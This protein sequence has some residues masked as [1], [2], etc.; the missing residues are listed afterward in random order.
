[1]ARKTK[2]HF[3]CRG[4]VWRSRL[5]E[6]YAKSLQHDNWDVTSSGIDADLFPN[7]QLGPWAK[8]AERQHSLTSWFS[9]RSI[10]TTSEL[11]QAQ[12]I[13]VFMRGD[14]YA[15]AQQRYEFNPAK[16]LTW[17][18]KDRGDWAKNLSISQK[19]QRTFKHVK[20]NVER[21][22]SDVNYGGW[23][24]IVSEDNRLQGFKMPISL[25]N[26][27]G[28]WHRCCHAVI[29]TPDRKTLVQKRS[30]NIIFAPNL[31]DVS[32]GG[33]VDAR[34]APERAM[35][36]EIKEELGLDIAED[37]LRFLEVN[38]L[39]SY[40]PRYK[41]YSKNFTYSYHVALAESKPAITVQASEVSAAIFVSN[42]RLQRLIRLHKLKGLGRLNYAYN[43]YRRTVDLANA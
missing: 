34:E 13:I 10:Q 12:D 8:I 4:N 9:D 25:T 32:I 16:S 6:A 14:V 38:K 33:H 19:R 7:R 24:D 36:R 23:V 5:A 21:L 40:H 22:I 28:L 43:Y 31:L 3:V 11:L 29:T 42:L 41:R 37:Q 30:A 2:I 26:K 39:Q 18:I 20:G 27:K 1:M 17:D 15:D 35:L